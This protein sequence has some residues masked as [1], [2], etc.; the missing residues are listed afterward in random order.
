MD[1]PHP[2]FN[3]SVGPPPPGAGGDPQALVLLLRLCVYLTSPF[4]TIFTISRIYVRLRIYRQMKPDDYLCI[5][6]TIISIALCIYELVTYTR[7]P[8]YHNGDN[9]NPGHHP[10]GGDHTF[11]SWYIKSQIIDICLYNISTM[12]IKLSLLLFYLHL[13]RPQYYAKL[14]IWTG[15]VII[16]I[17]YT[18]CTILVIAYNGTGDNHNMQ[19]ISDGQLKKYALL[20]VI[21]QSVFGTVT[22]FFVLAIPLIMISRLNLPPGKKLGVA[23][24]FL[25]GFISCIASLAN[26]LARFRFLHKGP[27]LMTLTIICVSLGILETNLGIICCCL[28]VCFVLFKQLAERYQSTWVSVW[29]YINSHRK[30][31]VPGDTENTFAR[32]GT[33]L[34][35]ILPNLPKPTISR[36]RSIMRKTPR[37]QTSNTQ[38]TDVN[39]PTYLELQSVDYEYQAQNGTRSNSSNSQR[40]D[41]RSH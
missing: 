31:G 36:L 11:H 29:G 32:T 40:P 10:K 25:T 6:A 19:G 20:L 8:G 30:S 33:G 21:A 22:D 14:L 2:G 1:S 24:I 18:I 12:F 38:M 34:P 41:T 3:S 16:T 7:N 37:T 26:V 13:F 5:I 15:V 39:D 23:G 17:F 28:P 4:V 35:N 27:A 9:Q